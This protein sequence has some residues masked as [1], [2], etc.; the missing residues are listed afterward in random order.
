MPAP[1]VTPQPRKYY[2]EH[3]VNDT[4]TGSRQVHNVSAM[5]SGTST[6]KASRMY[7]RLTQ[8]LQP[9]HDTA[10]ATRLLRPNLPRLRFQRLLSVQ[11]T[12]TNRLCQRPPHH[13]SHPRSLPPPS[14]WLTSSHL[15]VPWVHLLLNQNM[16]SCRTSSP[17][18]PTR[19]RSPICHTPPW[20]AAQFSHPQSTR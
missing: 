1:P 12:T 17:P 20:S 19:P 14:A 18:D 2:K 11:T 13:L 4:D 10:R 16:M 7:F 8:T 6:N 5:F 15:L 9:L 3:V